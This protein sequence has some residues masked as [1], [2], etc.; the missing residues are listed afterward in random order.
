MGDARVARSPAGFEHRGR[1]AVRQ[2]RDLD[3]VGES[4]RL[5]RPVAVARSIRLRVVVL[6]LSSLLLAP[7]GCTSNP[8]QFMGSGQPDA[9]QGSPGE[10]A[11]T[12]AT[13][14][15]VVVGG[16]ALAVGGT[17]VGLWLLSQDEDERDV[18]S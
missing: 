9:W 14:V 16:A 1:C 10:S 3:P 13:Q 12:A 4:G 5:G 15:G 17:L 7:V 2:R 6:A 11:R 18:G 8:H